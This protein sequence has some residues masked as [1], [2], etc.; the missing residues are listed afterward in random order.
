MLVDVHAHIY[1]EYFNEDINEIIEKAKKNNVVSII[2]AGINHETNKEVIE[3]SKKFSILKSS[4]GLYPLEGIKLEEDQINE[5]INFI[6]KNRNKIIA[7]GEVGL[8]YHYVK[9]KNKEQKDIFQKIINIAEKLDLPIVVHSRGAE[10]DCVEMLESSKIKK[11]IMHS[12][13]GNMKLIKRIGDNGWTFS[14]PTNVV[15]STQFQNIVDKTS[16][17]KILTET[18]SPYLSPKKNERNEPSNII[19]SI[20]KISDIKKLEKEEIEKLIFLNFQKI[21]IK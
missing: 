2:N 18:D 20:K 9:N 1:K 19:Y 16:I 17:S 4:L 7:I 10:S 3:L 8:D 6:E 5:T 15:Y 12:F 21:F 14:I 13:S 11:I